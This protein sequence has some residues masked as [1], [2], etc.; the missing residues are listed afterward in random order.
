MVTDII[1]RFGRG[2][3]RLIITCPECDTKYRYE[4][5]RFGGAE[6][7]QV[8]CTSC[9]HSFEVRNPLDEPSSATSIGKMFADSPEDFEPPVVD[10]EPEAPELPKLASLPPD[11][12]YSLA[13]IAGSQA[14]SVFPIT[15]PRVYLGRGSSM[16]IQIK[17]SEVSRKHS[18]IEVRGPEVVLIDLGATNGTWV[19]G[20][21]ADEAEI[22]NQDEFTVGSTTLMLIVTGGPS[23]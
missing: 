17:D 23:A 5:A 13:V 16:D 18:M 4:E 1:E 15:K 11:K 7:K 9:G 12:R 21:R 6:I 22:F 14:G 19:G 8:K 2:G 3:I 10:D 20:E